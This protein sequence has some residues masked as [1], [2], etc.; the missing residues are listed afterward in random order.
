MS[1]TLADDG[2]GKGPVATEV[3]RGV[4]AVENGVR[5]PDRWHRLADVPA[6]GYER[7]DMHDATEY[8]W[9]QAG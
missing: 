4:P 9:D 8:D 1:Y 7:N 2:H 6:D 5:T 3:R